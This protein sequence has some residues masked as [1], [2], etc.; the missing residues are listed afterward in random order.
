MPSEIEIENISFRY[1]KAG[2]DSLSHVSLS[3]PRGSFFAL[4]GPNGA[5][6]T[7]LLR[8]LCGRF[9]K[10]EGSLN[11]DASLRNADGFLDSQK[12]GVLLENPGIYPKL[13]VEEY[14]SYFAGF[15]GMGENACLPGG[16][17]RARMEM[18]ASQLDIQDLKLRM[19]ALSLGNRQKVQILRAMLPSPK[20]LIL[21][22]PVAN[23]D[24]M[25]REKVWAL[26]EQW[27][28]EEGGTAIVCSHVLAEMEQYA[29]HY[30]I[31]DDG[32]ILKTGEVSSLESS[33]TEFS[34]DVKSSVD[35]D[36]IRNA[37]AA[38]GIPV[39]DVSAHKSSLAT[40]YR[41]TVRK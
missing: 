34:V 40:V 12:Y 14:L 10:F 20:L 21:D 26:V 9:R 3:I 25:A 27:R 38:A 11:I 30:A 33:R 2:R 1:P 17:A 22:E 39:T 18:L 32:K 29:S 24:P 13:S 15:Y 4:L 28:R 36:A 35:V 6:K 16:S 37:L 19:G 7:T 5:G 41:E 8:L 23:L 31:I